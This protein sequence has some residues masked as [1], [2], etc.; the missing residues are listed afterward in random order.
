MAVTLGSKVFVWGGE[1]STSDDRSFLWV[2]DIHTKMWLKRITKGTPPQGFVA[3][4]YTLIDSVLYVFG[5]ADGGKD[6]GPDGASYYNDIY[7]IE[8]DKDLEWKKCKMENSGQAPMK[9]RSTGM[10]A[11]K[12]KKGIYEL[13]VVGG[14]G[15]RCHDTPPGSAIHRTNEIH[16]FNIKKGLFV[17]LLKSVMLHVA[18]MKHYTHFIFSG[19]WSAQ[20]FRR[21]NRVPKWDSFTITKIDDEHAVV[22][23]GVHEGV[24][25]INDVYCLQVQNNPATDDPEWV[26]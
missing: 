17:F 24:G 9:K 20:A 26:C 21:G 3:C 10:I 23:A 7:Q 13:V 4:A 12:T 19:E 2:F 22:F 15:G 1:G 16:S 18:S 14:Y 11:R 8:L 25:A 6:G 5:G